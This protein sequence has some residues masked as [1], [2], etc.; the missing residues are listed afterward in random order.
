MSVP[1]RIAENRRVTEPPGSRWRAVLMALIAI[2]AGMLLQTSGLAA[3]SE[4][5]VALPPGVRAVWEWERA[6]RETTP[7]RERVCLNGLWEWQPAVLGERE[8]PAK[9]WGWFKV[10]G[11]WPGLTD[12]MQK[13]SQTVVAHP[14]WA[15]RKLGPIK[16]AWYQRRLQVPVAWKGRRV[17]IQADTL[18]SWAQ[19]YVDGQSAGQLAFPGGELEISRHCRP[20][21]EVTLTLLVEALPLNAVM[22]AHN[23]SASAREVEGTVRRRGLC[24]DV[25]L[26]ATPQG[27]RIDEVRVSTSVRRGV[28]T[29]DAAVSALVEGDRYRLRALVTRDGRQVREWS[30]GFFGAGDLV[31]G[32]TVLS[33]DW[34]PEGLWDTHTPSNAYLVEVRLERDSGTVLDVSLPE[35][36]GFREFWIEGRDF[37]LNGK[38]LFL[39]VVPLDLAQVSAATATYDAARESLG[40]LRAIGINAVYT[41]HYDC[42]PGAHLGFGE[43]LKAA[44][45]V[46]MLVSFSMPHFSHYDWTGKD[47]DR[48]NGYARHADAYRRMAQNHPSVVM[49]S[50]SHNATGY[51]DDMNPDLMD[52][53]HEVRDSWSARNAARALRAEAIVK[54]LD[55]TRVIYHHASGNLGSMHSVNFYPNFAPIQELSDWFRHWSEAG[56]KPLF[57]C[58]YGAPFSW[59]WTMYRG[60]HEGRREFGSAKVPWEFCLAEWNAQFLGDTAYRISEAE[61]ANLRWEAV[62]FREGRKWHRWDYP[63]QVSSTVFE[64]RYPVFASYLTDHW[65]AF[66]TWGVSG[67]SPWEYEHFWRLREGVDRRRRELPVDWERLQRP[68]FSPD[69]LDQQYER[70]DLAYGRDDWVPTAAAK[71]LIRNNRPLLAYL[72]GRAGSFTSKSHIF[73][74]GEVVEKQAILINHSREDVS[75]V[76]RWEARFSGTS[77]DARPVRIAAGDQH[78]LPLRLE[79]PPSTL[80]GRDTL[81]LRVEF[82]TGEVQEDAFEVRIVGPSKNAFVPAP[83]AVFDP[84]GDTMRELRRL[85]VDAQPVASTANLSPQQVLVI[86]RG[87][88][89]AEGPGLDLV[90]V[91]GGRRVVV[92]EQEAAVLEKRLGFR[93][94]EY[95]LRQVFPRLPDHPILE[96]IDA[97][98]LRDWRG[99]A[100]LLPP[101]ATLTPD[102]AYNGAPTTTWCGLR[103]PRLWR[104]GNQGSVASVLIEKPARGD[105]LPI[106]DG[107]FSLQ[108]SP[109][110]EYR[111][112]SGAVWFCQLEVTGRT[113]IEPAAGRLIMNLLRHAA[114]WKPKPMRRL[115]YVG[116]PAGVRHLESLGL[117]VEPPGADPWS[118]DR[119]LVVG[120]G[121]GKALAG[122]IE[123]VAAWLKAGGTMLTV[124]LVAEELEAFLAP[125]W[126]IRRNEHI[127]AYFDPPNLSSPWAGVGAADGHLREPR[128]LPLVVGGADRLGDGWLAAR[129][130]DLGR[131]VLCQVVPWELEGRREPNARKTYRRTSFVLSRLLAN[132]G[133]A[134]PT[135]LL[136]RFGG[137]VGS[138]TGEGRWLRGLYLDRPE[139]WD[140]PYRFF[141][142]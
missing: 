57:L 141:R 39:S 34:M 45:D 74:A 48:T 80:P 83:L 92:F 142:W 71:A 75:A 63:H 5:T 103:V 11:C 107:G 140:D 116:E 134:M 46:G 38:R 88:L 102:P 89:S 36:F 124:G 117:S 56:V 123:P 85:G 91:R 7:T 135:P 86:G 13:D 132:L 52:G 128:E 126:S 2:A 81:R 109:L 72:A 98:V 121:G 67:I 14:A 22:L 12:Y 31:R 82:D 84:R 40:R 130:V 97:E 47:A 4:R 133:V 77:S 76:V 15:D 30:G 79:I 26:C 28:M 118:T 1:C 120:P 137:G 125:P 112:G 18:Q 129:E 100:T 25:F 99:E 127:S 55:P 69:F 61:K 68:G 59:D 37:Y 87:A 138:D 122:R 101:R 35:R 42:Q 54:D 53:I 33:T 95:G 64:E 58:E 20:G 105:F 21:E 50:M 23:D 19:V 119:V 73:E 111:E 104:C 44:D 108:F 78:R 115:A 10:P 27:P 41:H 32:R 90:G 70:M 65:R 49:Y 139:A 110:M 106:V 17:A 8:V 62:Q 93:V 43:I 113:E 94:T 9:N 114:A 96:G 16:A 3:S 24:G 66:R 136:D 131:V 6:F 51:N 60:W 29:V